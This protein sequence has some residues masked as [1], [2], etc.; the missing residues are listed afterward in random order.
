MDTH[1]V[2]YVLES[3]FHCGYIHAYGMGKDG[4][5][6]RYIRATRYTSCIYC[7][8]GQRRELHRACKDSLFREPGLSLR[9]SFYSRCSC[10]VTAAVSVNR[11]K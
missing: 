9:D 10:L 6:A 4:L 7:F 8:D 2:V 1:S 11:P 5:R 3:G